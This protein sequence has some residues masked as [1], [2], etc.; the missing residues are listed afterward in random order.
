MPRPAGVLAL[1][2]L[3]A[4]PVVAKQPAWSGPYLTATSNEG[5]LVLIATG[6]PS[7]GAILT[8]G[9]IDNQV[10][11][12]ETV[13]EVDCPTGRYRSGVMQIYETDA[14]GARGA[15]LLEGAGLTWR[16]FGAQDVIARDYFCSGLAG[17]DV[18]RTVQP[19]FSAWMNRYG[20]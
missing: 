20:G 11:R 14:A 3:L 10:R 18:H 13:L 1:M 6:D 2:L 19:A 15:L 7:P 4:T 5:S 16:P 12:I 9:R 17:D 8:Y